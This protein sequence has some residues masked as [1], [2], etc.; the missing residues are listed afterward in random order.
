MK[1]RRTT[2]QIYYDI[3]AAIMKECNGDE[4]PIKVTK[5]QLRAKLAFDKIKEHLGVMMKYKLIKKNYTITEKGFSY[6]KEFTNILFQVTRLQDRLH[7]PMNVPNADKS[8]V[9]LDALQHI[10][11][12]AEVL[13]QQAELSKQYVIMQQEMK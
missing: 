5:I 2:Q 1:E 6:Y 9:T 10:S 11:E 4:E 7:M 12:I 8:K 3:L 13:S